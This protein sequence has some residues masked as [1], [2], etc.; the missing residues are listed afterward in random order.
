MWQMARSPQ[1]VIPWPLQGKGYI[2]GMTF[3]AETQ[4][5]EVL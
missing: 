5:P 3:A 1:V 2:P 4:N